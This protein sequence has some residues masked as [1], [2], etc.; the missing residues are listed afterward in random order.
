MQLTFNLPQT[1]QSDFM[2]SNLDLD[3]CTTL[4]WLD[5]VASEWDEQEGDDWLNLCGDISEGELYRD[6]FLWQDLE[7][8]GKWEA[9]DP[10]TNSRYTEIDLAKLKA[11]ID[12][13]EATRNYAGEGFGLKTA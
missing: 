11:K 12:Q 9:Y 8:T 3:A 10:I 7:V 5:L 2:T 6:W 4:A 13:I 1:S